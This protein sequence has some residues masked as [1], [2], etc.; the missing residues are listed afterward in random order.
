MRRASGNAPMNAEVHEHPVTG[1][2]QL[3]S[4]GSSKDVL[5]WE[6]SQRAVARRERIEHDFVS[7]GEI[8]P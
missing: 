8:P 1:Q 7:S 5:S 6:V 3:W 4:P 2:G